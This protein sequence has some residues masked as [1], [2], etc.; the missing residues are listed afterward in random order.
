AEQMTI[1]AGMDRDACRAIVLARAGWHGGVIGIVA[2]RLVDRFCRPAV[3]I[4]LEN[5][6]GQG[7]GRSIRSFAICDALWACRQH[8]QS[9]GGHAM[10]AGLKIDPARVQPF[11]EAFLRHAN[12]ML[13]GKD[14]LPTLRL[15]GVAALG[16][17]S[18]PTAELLER[19]GP[20]G[21][22]NP[23]PRFATDWTR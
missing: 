12:Q 16:E 8:L 10:A 20:F 17:L 5:G 4:A 14:L 1:D 3:L 15:D 9:F 18:L 23:R 2:S 7:S 22:G 13:T 6:Q 19:L 21:V 11:S